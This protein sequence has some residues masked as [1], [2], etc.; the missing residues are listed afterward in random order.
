M[1]EL[2]TKLQRADDGPLERLLVQH[3]VLG[4]LQ[5]HYVETVVAQSEETTLSIVRFLEDRLSRAQRRFLDATVSLRET[6]RLL[7]RE[8][9]R[10]ERAGKPRKRTVPEPEGVPSATPI[11]RLAGAWSAVPV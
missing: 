1:D 4:Y 6:R 9:A 8:Q 11:N 2:E 5:V 3:V 7:A 10:K